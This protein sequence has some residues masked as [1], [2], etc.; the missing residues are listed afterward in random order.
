MDVPLVVAGQSK[1]RRKKLG[2]VSAS[3]V[4]QGVWAPVIGVQGRDA[5][6]RALFFQPAFRVFPGITVERATGQILVS[7]GL[8][9]AVKI[10]PALE[11]LDP[12]LIGSATSTIAGGWVERSASLLTG[13]LTILSRRSQHTREMEV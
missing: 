13:R 7:A 2:P 10:G 9:R 11:H 3:Q 4:C 5:I 1:R 12:D 6:D 8:R